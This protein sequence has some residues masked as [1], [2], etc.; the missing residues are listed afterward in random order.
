MDLY[1]RLLSNSETVKNRKIAFIRAYFVS[2]H[3]K[4][5]PLK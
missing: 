1:E 5:K 2:T 3:A 4:I